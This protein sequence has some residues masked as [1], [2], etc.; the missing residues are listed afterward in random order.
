MSDSGI[1]GMIYFAIAL[2]SGWWIGHLQ[3]AVQ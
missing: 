3:C 2:F 1:I